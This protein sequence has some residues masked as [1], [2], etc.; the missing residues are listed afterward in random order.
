M[1]RNASTKKHA[2]ANGSCKYNYWMF[3][4]PFINGRS[5]WH[6]L[7]VRTEQI[8][9]RITLPMNVFVHV[10]GFLLPTISSDEQVDK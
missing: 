4:Y 1:E 7:F 8:A 5:L 2:H 3:L 10:F 6:S 9:L